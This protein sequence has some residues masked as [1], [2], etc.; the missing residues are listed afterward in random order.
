MT[1]SMILLELQERLP[2]GNFVSFPAE[3]YRTTGNIISR[4][5]KDKI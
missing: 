4:A 3:I 2:L 5:I 1:W